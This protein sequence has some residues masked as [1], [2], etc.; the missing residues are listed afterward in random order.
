MTTTTTAPSR[1][2]ISLTDWALLLALSILWGGSFVLAKIAVA[3]VPPITVS[4]VRI[5]GAALL[6]WAVMRVR[7]LPLPRDSASWLAFLPL[8]LFNNV[9]PFTLMYWAQLHIPA[10]LGAILNATTP[11]FGMLLA[12]I[13]TGDERLSAGRL[14]GLIAGF[15]GVV[16]MIGPDLLGQIGVDVLAQGA[17]LL[18]AF[19]FGIGA[20]AGRR[21]RG[22]PPLTVAT[23]QLMISIVILAPA[24]LLFDH[25]WT[26]SMPSWTAI[27][28]IVALTVFSTA[29]AYLLFF[30]ILARIGATNVLLV[31]FVQPLWAVL[32]GAIVFAERLSGVQVLGMVGIL[33]GLAVIDGRILRVFRR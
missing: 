33:A 4:F 28:T 14:F 12:L 20:L 25:P 22:I 16:V 23:G 1:L 18:A 32:L 3:E 29:L 17:A 30:T 7:G 2:T 8:S 24:S 6:L 21:L 19:C 5:T 11:F 9:V 27:W 10:G 15:A 31:T 26:L 13:F